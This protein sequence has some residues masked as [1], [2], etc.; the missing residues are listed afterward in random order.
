L[1]KPG[2]AGSLSRAS[3]TVGAVDFDGILAF[4]NGRSGVGM[5][6]VMCLFLQQIYINDAGAD[7]MKG[8][9]AWADK[10]PSDRIRTA[11]CRISM[12]L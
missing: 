1:R 11:M 5:K 7:W 12:D 8:M 3:A 6:I 4:A 10:K 9:L 2:C